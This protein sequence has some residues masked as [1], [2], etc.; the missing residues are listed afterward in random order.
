MV[1]LVAI[2]WGMLAGDTQQQASAAPAIDDIS[3]Q[4]MEGAT[5]HEHAHLAIYNNGQPVE[6][7]ANIGIK[8]GNNC[9]YWLHTHDA[10]GELHIESPIARDFTLGNF[11][12]IWGEQLDA[13]HVMSYTNGSPLKVYVDGKEFTGDPRTIQLKRHTLVTVEVGPNFV[14][15]AKFDFPSGD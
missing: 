11:F 1:L 10:T 12:N 9:L 7:P 14:E 8:P 6:V 2:I 13:T 4:S 5:Q 15:P 3:C